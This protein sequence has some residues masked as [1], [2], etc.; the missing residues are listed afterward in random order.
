MTRILSEEKIL[1]SVPRF[2]ST[3]AE[4]DEVDN[5][6]KPKL[7]QSKVNIVSI[8]SF[9]Y[10]EQSMNENISAYYKLLKDTVA[11]Y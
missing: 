3:G 1:N 5:S 7:K 8:S 10:V 4:E 2:K 11:I 6:C 9:R